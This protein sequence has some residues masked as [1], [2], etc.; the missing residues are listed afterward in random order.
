MK[1][2][3]YRSEQFWCRATRSHQRC[4]SDI[5]GNLELV[6]DDLERRDKELVAHN[7]QR[8]EHVEK[9]KDIEQETS[10]SLL[11]CVKDLWWVQ[12]DQ[13]GR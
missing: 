1:L 7:G 9:A 5:L 4:T 2:A 12:L 6:N 8:A 10:M 13:R 11:T 3:Y